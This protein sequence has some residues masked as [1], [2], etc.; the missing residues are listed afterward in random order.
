MKYAH[1]TTIEGTHNHI[2]ALLKMLPPFTTKSPKKH[3]HLYGTTLVAVVLSCRY[4][5]A[6]GTWILVNN[7][8]ETMFSLMKV[9]V[10][11]KLM[12]AS[13]QHHNEKG[14]HNLQL[15]QQTV[16]VCE[17]VRVC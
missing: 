13:W 17:C 15:K 11:K 5:G 9:F 6:Y 1:N 7:A 12:V 16:C 8:L 2:Q 3:S 10:R 4:D 14:H